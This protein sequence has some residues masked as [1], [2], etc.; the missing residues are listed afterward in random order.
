MYRWRTAAAVSTCSRLTSGKPSTAATTST[1]TSTSWSWPCRR[2]KISGSGQDWDERSDDGRK[3]SPEVRF[4]I[5]VTERWLF[6]GIYKLYQKF[7]L[8]NGSLSWALMF[9]P[10]QALQSPN[11]KVLTSSRVAFGGSDFV[12][13]VSDW[14]FI[15]Y[16]D[17][18]PCSRFVT[19]LPA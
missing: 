6:Q 10:P 19:F 9:R 18:Y 3:K 5:R 11:Y 8:H 2:R 16:S 12:N 15:G 1:S 7:F 4:W 13:D 17:L 14:G